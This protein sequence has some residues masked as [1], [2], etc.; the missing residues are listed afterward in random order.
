[1]SSAVQASLASYSSGGGGGG[2]L[3]RTTFPTTFASARGASNTA[4]TTAAF[5]TSNSSL[6]VVIGGMLADNSAAN[7]PTGLTISSSPTLTWTRQLT[8]GNPVQWGYGIAIWT[9]PVT[10]GAS[11]TVT[12]GMGTDLNNDIYIKPLGYTNYKTATPIGG[13]A[14][15]T[16]ANGT[17][18]A[19]ITLSSTPAS[20]SEIIAVLSS[21]V[22]SGT[23]TI[24]PGSTFTEMDEQGETGWGYFEVQTK[25]GTTS[26]TVDWV[27]VG[28][29]AS[30]PLEAMLCALEIQK[31]P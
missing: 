6:L 22:N 25:T 10:S 29:S 21:V 30:A 26:T 20:T 8:T 3:T 14:T 7:R 4:V 27:D 12:I 23:A 5:T 17:G 1:M 15:G 24:T 2:A 13:T 16:D 9:A 28:A 19:S 18:P 31:G 11:T